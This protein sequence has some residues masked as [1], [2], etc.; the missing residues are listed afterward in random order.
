MLEILDLHRRFG[1]VVALDGV[2][3]GVAP[4]DVVGA[5]AV[6]GTVAC[7]VHGGSRSSAMKSTSGARVA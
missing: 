4:G 1:D 5:F 3:F 2:T 6:V 7:L